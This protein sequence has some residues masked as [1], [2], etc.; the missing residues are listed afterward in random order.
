[1]A[2]L[3]VS[4][5]TNRL[6]RFGIQHFYV[7]VSITNLSKH[8]CLQNTPV[9][10]Y[11]DVYLVLRIYL[12]FSGFHLGSPGLCFSGSLLVTQL[13]WCFVMINHV[14]MQSLI[15]MHIC[16]V[17]HVIANAFSLFTATHCH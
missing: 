10:E 16:F 11:I 4:Q 9:I 12:D 15:V 6:H 8:K 1:M 3:T 14:K 13:K 17:S 5:P 7:L 2:S